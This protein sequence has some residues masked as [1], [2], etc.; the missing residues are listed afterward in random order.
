MT[1]YNTARA[2][3]G[4]QRFVFKD[5]YFNERENDFQMKFDRN[6]KMPKYK[7][8]VQSILTDIER[9][10]LKKGTQLPSI[11]ELSVDYLLARDTVEKAYREL[12]NQG[13]I[14]SVQGK[15]YYVQSGQ[16]KKIK[17][18]LVFNK[19]SSYK[20][21]IYYSFIKALGDNVV[22]DLEIHHYSVKRFREII[23]KNLG[24]YNHY[25]IMP[26]F[27]QTE[28]EDY[29][30]ILK[31]IPS[32]QLVLLDREI[33]ELTQ[34]VSS[35]YQSFDKDIFG[36]LENANDLMAK[37]QR[38]VL[39]FPFDGNYPK[40]IV[41]GFRNYCINYHK[42]FEVLESVHGENLLPGTAYIVVEENDL[43]ELVK[44][45]RQSSYEMGTEV[46]VISFNETT[47][48][49]LLGITVITTD[50]ENMGRTA[51]AL[52]LN[53]EQIKVKNPFFMIRRGSL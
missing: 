46:G 4:T 32:S 47:L 40:E 3:L 37:Y 53:K 30:D 16:D 27:D 25:V 24:Q 31:N 7:Q 44:K 10:I 17:I 38:M 23:E 28:E 48:K 19:L 18:L 43:A 2:N 6:D 29:M 20:K 11:S 41:S 21:I 33:P 5:V 1:G 51:A 14:T 26:H 15:G 36:A 45:T 13:Y 35:I 50:F 12:R 9:G 52:I 22:V 42:D 39:V 49:E 34:P 8:I